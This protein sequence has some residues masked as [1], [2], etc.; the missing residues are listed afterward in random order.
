MAAGFTCLMIKIRIIELFSFFAAAQ[1]TKVQTRMQAHQT[2][3]TGLCAEY[4]EN[5]HS[6]PITAPNSLTL[7]QSPSPDS[8]NQNQQLLCPEAARVNEATPI[9]VLSFI[10]TTDLLTKPVNNSVHEPVTISPN[11]HRLWLPKSSSIHIHPQPAH[12]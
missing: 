12:K 11:P 1:V 9:S 6:P 10:Y 8:P 7:K 3:A 2:S 4:A 5:L